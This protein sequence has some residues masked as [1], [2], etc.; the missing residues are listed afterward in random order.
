MEVHVVIPANLL[1]VGKVRNDRGLL[2]TKG[3]ID[4]VGHIGE[5]HF[6]C[7][8]L[9]L[10]QL[11]VRK[12]VQPLD[13]VIQLVHIDSVSLQ[14]FQT[15]NAAFDLLHHTILC[16]RVSDIQRLQHLDRVVVLILRDGEGDSDQA[17]FQV[18]SVIQSRF[19]PHAP[20]PFRSVF[21]LWCAYSHPR[22]PNRGNRGRDRGSPRSGRTAGTLVFVP[23]P[24]H[25]RAH[26]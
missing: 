4:E 26:S 23:A 6:R 20:T 25:S 16:P 19:D 7:H 8:S 1:Q 2:T 9:E 14:A 17:I 13:E 11:P 5:S 10:G 12:T 3:Q 24:G 18:I 21:L 22:R 15:G